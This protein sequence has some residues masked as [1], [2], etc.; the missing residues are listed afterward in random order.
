LRDV[1]KCKARKH[2]C[3]WN[4]N[5]YGFQNF[6]PKNRCLL[7]LKNGLK[8]LYNI[9]LLIELIEVLLF[10]YAWQ[11]SYWQFW[12][13]FLSKLNKNL[14]FGENFLQN[15]QYEFVKPKQIKRSQLVLSIEKNYKV[16]SHRFWE[17]GKNRFFGRKFWH[18]WK[19]IL[20][21]CQHYK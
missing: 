1:K 2:Q 21:R 19:F 15:F 17:N 8:K 13:K 6:L 4:I 3:I 10:I 5:F 20:Q 14:N 16:S 12:R 11:N 9:S 18:P 7:F